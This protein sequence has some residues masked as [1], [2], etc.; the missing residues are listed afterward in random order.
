MSE[1]E[2]LENHA[3]PDDL[4][5]GLVRLANVFN[6]QTGV[7]LNIGGLLITGKMVSGR[8]YYKEFAGQL[9]N[10][11]ADPF[12]RETILALADTYE[13]TGEEL[14]PPYDF[15]KN[16]RDEGEDA[17]SEISEPDAPLAFIHL[18]DARFTNPGGGFLPAPGV[19][20]RGKLSSVDG[21]ILGELKVG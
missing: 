9:R 20:W 19:L 3:A 2:K 14:Y 4:L 16:E 5:E 1:E 21:F 15:S 7:T 11:G 13:K 10:T 18:I 6:I 12:L 8:R 17:K